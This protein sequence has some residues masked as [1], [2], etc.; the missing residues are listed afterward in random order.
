MLTSAVIQCNN[1]RQAEKEENQTRYQDVDLG[2]DSTIFDKLK[3]KRSKHVINN[4]WQAEK[5]ENQ[6]RY[7]DVDL[8]CDATIFDKLKK[9][10]I[11]HA[12]KM[13]TS[14]VIQQ[15][16]TSWKRRESNT[17]ARCWPRLWFNNF[18]Q[19]EKEENQ[20]RYQDVDLDCD[21]IIF[22]KLKKK[23]IKHAIKIMTSVVIPQIFDKLKKKRIKHAIKML[24]SA[25]IQQF[26][27]SWKRRESNTLSRCWPIKMLTSAVIQQFLTNWKRRESNTL[28]RYWPRLWFNNFWQAEKE[29]NQTRYQDVDLGCNSTIFDKLKKKRIKH[30]I[31]MLTSAVI[32]Q[33]LISWK[34]RESNTISDIKIFTKFT[35]AVSQQFLTSWKRRESNTLSRCWPQ[36]WCNNFWQ[37]EKEENQ[38]RYQDVDLGCDSTIFDKLK[39]KRIKHASKMLTSAVSQ[40]FLTSWKRRESNMLS[41]CWP[42]LW[43][44]NFWHA[45]KQE[46]QS[47]YQDVDLGCDS[48]IFDKLKKKRIKHNIRYQDIY[49]IY[50]GCD[51]TIFDKLKKKR[52]KY[53]IKMSALIQ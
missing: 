49:E 12:I 33:F 13:L 40:Q 19:A 48:T 36:L 30:A 20:T 6:T 1:F 16:L 45:E 31:K 51:S 44:N 32:Q 24:T 41:R 34:R 43:C 5:E 37:A 35:S 11:N 28:S 3:T 53:V 39:K 4:F 15:F 9:K 27:T 2:C 10:R 8:S 38:S 17:L 22:N 23:R 42:Q 29:D 25:V 50:L 21:S 14:A 7:Q 18:W 46:N 26:L 47:R 52:I